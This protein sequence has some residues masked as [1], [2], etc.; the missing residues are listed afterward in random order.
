MPG[1]TSTPFSS[2]EF[3]GKSK[4]GPWGDSIEELDWSTGEIM[5]KLEE[6]DL[7]KNTLV[8]WTSDNGAPI[9]R[10]P[11]DLSRGSNL[12]LHGR[13][14]TTS[15]GAFRVPTIMWWPGKVPAD[16]VCEEL[17]S[18]MDLFPTFAKMAG[19]KKLDDGKKRD[20]HDI[21]GLIL[22]EENAKTPHDAY[23]YYYLDQLQAVRSGP[24]KLFLPLK[25]FAQ[26]PHFRKKKNAAGKQTT[27]GPALFDVVN[28]IG[29]QKN[30][31]DENPEVVKRL[32]KLAQ[33][34]RK[35]LGDRG[36]PGPGIRKIGHHPNP[37]PVVK[38]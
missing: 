9:N 23:Y 6:L 14:Y 11:G 4:N 35:D 24:W 25:D 8:V 27:Y 38:K 28:D 30:V 1:S 7:A 3:R 19:A 22:A 33:A 26:H 34:M 37:V 21:S 16:T 17:A 32:T 36:K 13:G 15:E 20:G 31:A 18:T 2:P 29:C 12:P 10:T 5:E